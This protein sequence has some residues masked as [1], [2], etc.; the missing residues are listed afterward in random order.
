[1]A[2]LFS[3]VASL[4]MQISENSVIEKVFFIL[5]SRFGSLGVG[6][7]FFVSGFCNVKSLE[8]NKSYLS[9][10]ESFV[11]IKKK[12]A[13]IIVPFVCCFILISTVLMICCSYSFQAMLCD[14]IMIRI[15]FT[16]T[17]YL[18][19]Q[20]LYYVMLI[21]S[22]R[23]IKN[24]RLQCL[25]IWGMS[26]V[27]ALSFFF[28]GSTWWQGET[29]LCFALGTL[30]AK[31]ENKISNIIENKKKY[32]FAFACLGLVSGYGLVCF[33]STGIPA[34]VFWMII[35]FSLS[36]LV[37][38]MKIYTNYLEKVGEKSLEIYL[39]HIGLISCCFKDKY[40]E[41]GVIKVIVGT[42]CLCIIVSYIE[43]K[44]KN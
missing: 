39:I 37:H 2:I 29:G 20:I 16:T 33:K 44:I 7:F 17:W 19:I 5:V 8:Y 42:I 27:I 12:F 28:T 15:P 23:Y 26:F 31:Y 14:I 4:A 24:D 9:T 30:I 34:M 18:K 11:W 10:K 21:V 41:T 25:A 40:S 22:M 13:A 1:M 43:K 3:H 36:I 35:V 38:Y 6:A 32:I